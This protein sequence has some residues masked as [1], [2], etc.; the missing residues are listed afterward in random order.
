MSKFDGLHVVL[1]GRRADRLVEKGVRLARPGPAGGRRASTT[2]AAGRPGRLAQP[3]RPDGHSVAK[4]TPPR[5]SVR[6]L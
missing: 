5:K 4:I 1:S 6:N 3:R 2:T